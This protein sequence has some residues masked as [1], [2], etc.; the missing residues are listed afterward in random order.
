MATNLTPLPEFPKTVV[1]SERLRRNPRELPLAAIAGFFN[2]DP[3]TGEG[4]GENQ[5][6]SAPLECYSQREISRY[7]G[8]VD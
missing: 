2:E 6:D 7:A 8:T 1:P 5:D 3:E 4:G